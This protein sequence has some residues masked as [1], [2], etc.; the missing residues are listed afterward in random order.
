MRFLPTT[1]P[2]PRATLAL[3][4]LLFA[5]LG[6]SAVAQPVTVCMAEDNPP[7][8]YAVKADTRG[9]DVRLAQ[10]LAAELKRE[11]RIVPFESK[12]EGETTL[13][14]E[15]NALLSSGVCDI[16]S[17]FSLLAG[18]LGPPGRPT[19][20][21]PDHPGAK[22]RP[23]RPWVPLGTLVPS[24]A[25]HAMAMGL[26]V[27]DAERAGATLAEPGD[28]RIGIITGTLSGTAVSMFRGGKLRPQIVSL[29]RTENV[30]EQLEAKRFDA[31]LVALDRLDAWR[32]AHP[33]TTLRRT[34]Y[35]H[36]F[37]INIGFVARNDA[38]EVLAAANRVI[39]RALGNGDLQRWATESGATWVA[40][41][42]PQ[43][44]APFALA[45]L[46]RE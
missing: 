4:P 14:Q 26:V 31:A 6:A 18:D 22:R 12:L 46:L 11:L 23:L 37:R 43:V 8:S 44:G 21:V 39:E 29:S 40:P 1:F 32:I 24:L 33:D 15:V 28:A 5:T 16:A 19:A 35:L 25:Y 36:P 30:L 7:L 27:R 41:A 38:T 2:P 34:P 17:G 3:V 10:A 45:D 13:S 42:A 20:R 9:L